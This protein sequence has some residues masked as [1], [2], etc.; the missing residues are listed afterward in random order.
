MYKHELE[1]TWASYLPSQT[2]SVKGV[3]MVR[4]HRSD[5]TSDISLSPAGTLSD[6]S[7]DIWHRNPSV[8]SFFFPVRQLRVQQS[9]GWWGNSQP[10]QHKCQSAFNRDNE[11]Q[12]ESWRCDSGSIPTYVATLLALNRYINEP[13]SLS[14]HVLQ[15]IDTG[16]S[17]HQDIVS[18][19]GGVQLPRATRKTV[20]SGFTLEM[21]HCCWLRTWTMSD[22]CDQ[23]SIVFDTPLL[24]L[25]CLAA[26][27][28]FF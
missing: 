9:E 4:L 26:I 22:S 8:H 11:L 21:T 2:D 12:N 13:R 17:S 27:I 18:C 19:L 10:L 7:S 28:A 6:R 25:L 16:L 23:V 1:R 5:V 14:Y 20:L 24:I 3:N 15:V